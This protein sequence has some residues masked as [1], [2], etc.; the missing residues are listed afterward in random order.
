MNGVTP[1][2]KNFFFGLIWILR[3]KT[4]PPGNEQSYNYLSAAIFVY[5][6]VFNYFYFLSKKI[7]KN[8]EQSYERKIGIK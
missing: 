6:V 1:V 4:R 7:N 3:P 5:L 8:R 2:F